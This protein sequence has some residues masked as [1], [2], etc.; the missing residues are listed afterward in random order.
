M[1]DSR[2]QFW[3]FPTSPTTHSCWGVNY[4]FDLM[5]KQAKEVRFVIFLDSSGKHTCMLNGTHAS[6]EKGQ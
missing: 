5:W 2:S 6:V 1:V 4:R 3:E